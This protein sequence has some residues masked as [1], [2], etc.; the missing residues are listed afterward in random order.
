MHT[1]NDSDH[2]IK[3]LASNQEP[4]GE[5][6][7]DKMRKFL[8]SPLTRKKPANVQYKTFGTP[9]EVL[10]QRFP[11]EHS[12]PFIITRLC[13]YILK[14]GLTHEGL[15]RISGN[16]RS[17]ERLKAS[18]DRSGDAPL[19]TEGDVS[20]AAAL[21]KLFLRELPDPIIPMNMHC[22]FLD[23]VK[24]KDKT[25]SVVCL[26]E[27]VEKLPPINYHILNY[28]FN[29]L[30][31]VSDMEDQNRMSASSLGIV[32][33]PNLFRVTEDFV[34]LKEQSLT[35]QIVTY[36][37]SEHDKIFRKDATNFICN[38]CFASD[39][40]K[41]CQATAM[42]SSWPEAKSSSTAMLSTWSLGPLCTPNEPA[43]E[44]FL[45]LSSL[46]H[47][48]TQD[49]SGHFSSLKS[50]DH[51]FTSN[52]ESRFPSKDVTDVSF[53]AS[54]DL[55][56][57]NHV[58]VTSSR[59][60]KERKSSLGKEFYIMEEESLLSYSSLSDKVSSISVHS[61]LT[62][63]VSNSSNQS[64]LSE[65]T[66]VT[67]SYS[68]LAEKLSFNSAKENS[69]PIT[70]ISSQEGQTNDIDN[71]Q[72][73]LEQV[74][75]LTLEKSE[76]MMKDTH[77]IYPR[78][79]RRHIR[80]PKHK[81]YDERRSQSE[82]RTNTHYENEDEFN[83]NPHSL[84]DKNDM[85]HNSTGSLNESGVD[86]RHSWPA[87]RKCKEE[88]DIALSPLPQQLGTN[89]CEASVSP[90]AFRS[91]LSYRNLHLDPS[92]PPSP[93]VEQ[94]DIIIGST[95]EISSSNVKQLNKK[96]HTLK[97]K[98]KTFEDNFEKLYGYKPSNAEKCSNIS[99][100]KM[101][102][103]LN[104]AR[105]DLKVCLELKGDPQLWDS[106]DTIPNK[107]SRGTNTRSSQG[108][109]SVAK[110]GA[111]TMSIEET[112]KNALAY[113]ARH[114]KDMNRPENLEEMT[115]DQ[116]VAEKVAIQKV[117]LNFE[118]MH[119]RPASKA[120]RELVRP[121]YDRYRLTKRLIVRNSSSKD[122][123]DLVPILEHETMDFKK[124]DLAK[125]INIL[126]EDPSVELSR[127]KD[128][129]S[130]E[131]EQETSASSHI[132]FHELSLSELEIEIT[133]VR[134]EKRK[135]RKLLREFEDQFKK[136]HGRKAQR[137]DK[138]AMEPCYTEYKNAKAKLKL[139]E[140]LVAKYEQTS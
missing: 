100:K 50:Q 33:G 38:T 117:L 68:S 11:S 122:N 133:V 16:A 109:F 15:F 23:A 30:R 98:I 77:K 78:G 140:A 106:E 103:E 3:M 81:S 62:E 52:N 138:R 14:T 19:E 13:Q 7:I 51:S 34:G 2:S 41:T 57:E 18:F 70:C 28:L 60:P 121:L 127:N 107:S 45:Q 96:I 97:K 54:E 139:L 26:A 80:H 12:V 131:K 10:L 123:A 31:K 105:Q 104:K 24:D 42:I 88:E 1:L 61:L 36:F 124:S 37:I 46:S 69:H 40:S 32:F 129:H 58:P 6:R 56:Y 43:Y 110:T 132:S 134:D 4:P 92:L 87:F 119:G 66:P 85:Q 71:V 27:L 5:S 49:G 79:R 130:E 93:P 101:L 55:P 20:S 29:F 89:V 91:Y 76:E 94:E 65:T 135:L 120:H 136:E 44:E 116:L 86:V 115:K 126:K 102:S 112:I 59:S 90:S 114:R 118:S 22:Q 128:D 21:L 17:V 53:H 83:G 99:V 82:L 48:L 137:E 125:N 9:L 95:H 47:S 74:P 75:K 113:L 64:S 35:N 111:E 25:E 84:Y 67:S 39:V 8:S 72:F 73:G 108:L 63:S